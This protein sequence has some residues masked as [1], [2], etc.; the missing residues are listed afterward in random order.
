MDKDEI[1]VTVETALDIGHKIAEEISVL[2][3]ETARVA[4][5]LARIATFLGSMDMNLY[6]IGAVR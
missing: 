1:E 4:Q 5:E 6:Q 3:S 2:V